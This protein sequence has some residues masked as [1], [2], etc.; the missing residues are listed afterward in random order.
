MMTTEPAASRDIAFFPGCTLVTSAK[1][2]YQSLA[3]FCERMGYRLRELP[4]WNCCGTSSAHS[5]H[6][7]AAIDLP[8]RNLALAPKEGMLLVAC[9]SC[10]L[11]LRQ[12]HHRLVQD[13]QE[14]RRFASK[15]GTR[16]PEN[17]EILP[18]LAFLARLDLSSYFS[19]AGD[20]ALHGLRF[21]PYY[22][23]M[24]ARPASLPP[25][26]A[27]GRMMETALDR[28]GA[29]S[30]RWGHSTRCCGTFLAAARPDIVTPRVNAMMDS[31]VR[32]GAECIVT[33]CSMCHFSL[34]LRATR[35]P[36]MPVFHFAELLALAAGVPK[37]Q[38]WFKRHLV[39]PVPLLRGK[40]LLA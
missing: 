34:E 40:G 4:D 21:A 24:L 27:A 38:N 16:P 9:P 39:D 13:P 1:E 17:L 14:N 18:F 23:C 6:G 2:N 37:T 15:W 22:G 12:T 36:R 19:D 26:H 35:R 7:E 10:Y 28:L 3:S 31:A 25:R 30:L 20:R 29:E 33:A 11:R 8:A 5:I 32:A